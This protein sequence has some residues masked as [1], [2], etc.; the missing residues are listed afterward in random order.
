M[1]SLVSR[2]FTP[3]PLCMHT[4]AMAEIWSSKH[5]VVIISGVSLH[6][7]WEYWAGIW[8]KK[9]TYLLHCD[10]YLPFTWSH[11]SRPSAMH[12]TDYYIV[13]C[14][15][16]LISLFLTH[17]DS[18]WLK[19]LQRSH[20]SGTVMMMSLNKLLA[21]LYILWLGMQPTLMSNA[22]CI[23]WRASPFVKI[24]CM[25]LIRACSQEIQYGC[26]MACG[27][28]YQSL[29]TWYYVLLF[30]QLQCTMFVEIP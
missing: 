11:V 27:P 10:L 25:A 23:I 12:L 1:W 22:W 13:F 17:R 18:E 4:T 16:V 3:S 20:I 9:K 5:Q 21:L 19:K 30:Y 15:S 26:W 28:Q 6:S 8:P 14:M 29:L 7:S 24:T 2:V